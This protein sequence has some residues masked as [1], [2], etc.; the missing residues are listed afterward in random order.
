MKGYFISFEGP[1]GSGKSTVLKETLARISDRLTTQY[2]VTREPGGSKIAEAI[3]DL[4]LDPSHMEMDPKTEALLYAASRSQ[5]LEEIVIP[6]LEAGML[7]VSDRYIDSS[8]AYQGVGRNLGIPDVLA[9]ND[10]AT[11]GLMPDLTI[12]LDVPPE[13]GLA[14]IEKDRPGQEDR[15]EKEKLDFHRRVHEGYETVNELY[16]DRIKVIDANRPLEEVVND[17]IAT[18]Q[19]K[20]PDLLAKD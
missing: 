9:I 13:V 17:T 3:R 15:L 12:F 4:I 11:K 20:L 7:V 16:P 6:A 18:I 14:R 1:D 8:L 10:F 2:L 5:H 19:E